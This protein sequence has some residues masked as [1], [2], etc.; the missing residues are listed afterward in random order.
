MVKGL[1][2]YLQSSII[3]AS[4]GWNPQSG[5][6]KKAGAQWGGCSVWADK[7]RTAFVIAFQV[8]PPRM[9]SSNCALK[10]YFTKNGKKK[11][12][13]YSSFTC[14]CDRGAVGELSEPKKTLCNTLTRNT[15]LNT[16]K[17]MGWLCFWDSHGICEASK[18][19]HKPSGSL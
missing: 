14:N 5:I 6:S 4:H 15:A 1:P 2:L 17:P 7:R 8:D 13:N 3:G 16:F 10:G 11:K 19:R 9:Q 12:K 18:S